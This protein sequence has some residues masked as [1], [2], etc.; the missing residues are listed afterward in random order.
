MLETI[1]DVSSYIKKTVPFKG[2][3]LK[4]VNRLNGGI[5]N[6]IYRLTFSDESTA[7]LK[8]Y[9]AFIATN[10]QIPF[11]QSRYFVEK[12]ALE[13]FGQNKDLNETTNIRV[14]KV[15]FSDDDNYVIIMQD[16]GKELLLL[17]EVLKMDNI[18][19]EKLDSIAQEIYNFS[20][21]LT[22]KSNVTPTS[23]KDVFENP[24]VWDVSAKFG[25]M[26]FM[27]NAKKFNVEDKLQSFLPKLAKILEKS[28]EK[29]DV[30]TFGDLWPNSILVDMKTNVIWIID[31]ETTRFGKPLRDLEQLMGNLWVMKQSPNFFKVERIEKLMKNLQSK[32]FQNEDSDWRA[33]SGE[34]GKGKF[35]FWVVILIH[36][37]HFK[38]ENQ[39]DVVLKAL[40][41]IKK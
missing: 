21:F 9:P 12:S 33:A 34:D 20:K 35:I 18:S 26:T 14:P 37:D 1:E 30:L 24:A 40:D 29:N 7:V 15:L 4:S 11:S 13:I 22:E 16:A 31:W 2:L 23:H 25:T 27:T 36:H 32:F 3:D 39:R 19:D 6:Y 8:Y 28:T 10:K 38:I 17:S 41:E 5:I